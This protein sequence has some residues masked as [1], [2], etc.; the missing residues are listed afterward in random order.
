LFRQNAKLRRSD[1]NLI[2]YFDTKA[3]L[4][5]QS[6]R[7]LEQSGFLKSLNEMKL[8]GRTDVTSSAYILRVNYSGTPAHNA[9]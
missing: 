4:D 9:L 5:L 8:T 2:H 6:R 3:V 1:P 7:E